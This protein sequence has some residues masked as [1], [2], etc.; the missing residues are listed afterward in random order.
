MRL[1][2]HN[3]IPHMGEEGPYEKEG[4]RKETF[5]GNTK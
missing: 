1:K 4:R 5:K 2:R 3:E